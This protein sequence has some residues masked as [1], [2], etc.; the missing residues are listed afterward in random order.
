M[1]FLHDYSDFISVLV[2][3]GGA[4]MKAL[5]L[6]IPRRSM[7]ISVC[8]AGVMTYGTIG[9]LTLYFKDLS[10]KVMVLASFSIGWVANELTDKLDQFVNDAYDIIKAKLKS[11]FK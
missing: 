7:V 6:K 3:S 5:K 1:K 9:L 8:I 10:P 4:L 2:G 11:I